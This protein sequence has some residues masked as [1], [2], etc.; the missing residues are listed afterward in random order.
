[1][2]T[3][4]GTSSSLVCGL[5]QMASMDCTA[6]STLRAVRMH[7]STRSARSQNYANALVATMDSLAGA[8]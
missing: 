3:C 5:L 4:I 7:S 1:M 2:R 8:A 6:G